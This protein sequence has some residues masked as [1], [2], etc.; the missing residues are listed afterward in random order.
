MTATCSPSD[1]PRYC[2]EPFPAYRYLPF[3]P[4][5]P[6]PKVDPAGHSYGREDDDLAGFSPADWRQCQ[7]FLYGVDL[8]NNGYW[9]E[10]HEAWETIWLAA[11]QKTPTGQFIQGLI[12]L[13][14]GQ[15]K[16]VMQETRGA[17][18]LTASGVAKLQQ[19]AGCFLGI[20]VAPLL[21]AAKNSLHQ[22]GVVP[23]IRL[24]F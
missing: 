3:R 12:L 11:G 14:A 13:S 5:I 8:F 4:D 20:E 7:P 10:A 16:R 9:W 17:E 23:R 6:H 1:I 22:E 2:D 19:T 24:I 21:A 18:T 15:L